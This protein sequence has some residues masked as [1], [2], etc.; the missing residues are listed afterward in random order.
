MIIGDPEALKSP[1]TILVIDDEVDIREVMAEV[2]EH[3]GYCSVLLRSGSEAVAYLASGAPADAAIIDLRLPV[4]DGSEIALALRKMR[5]SLPMIITSGDLLLA[6]M[7]FGDDVRLLR[8]PFHIEAL[9]TT[10]HVVLVAGPK[11]RASPAREA[12]PAVARS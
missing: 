1:R 7:N 11:Q 12:A 4:M 9:D 3:L 10:L 8:K 2:L 5:P 6:E